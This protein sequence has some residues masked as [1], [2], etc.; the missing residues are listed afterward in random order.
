MT[1]F[2]ARYGFARDAVTLDNWRTRPFS[3]WSFQNVSEIVPSVLVAAGRGTEQP[4]EDNALFDQ[5][6]SVGERRVR[7][8]EFL[9]DS[10]T[11]IFT[12]MKKG[13]FVADYVATTCDFAGPHLL[14]SISKSLTA[15]LAGI[16]QDRGLL[17]PERPVTDF[18]PE[19]A[20]SAYGD[21]SLRH[22]LDMR[23]SVD[24]TEAYLD[25]ESA[26]ARYRRAMLWNPG[27]G[28]ETLRALIATLPKGDGP[29]GGPMR[30]LSP[31]SDLLG[32]VVE[33]I[34]GQRYGDMLREWLLEP[35]G[36]VGPCLVTNDR[37]GT[38]RAAGGVSLTARDLAR[39]GEMMRNGGMA[40]SRAVL[41]EAWVR[42]TTTAGDKDAWKAGDFAHLF[43]EG[44]YRNQWYQSG[45]QEGA[46]CAIGIHG[47]WL[48]VDPSA[49]VVIVR[50]A[51][52]NEPVDDALDH[53]C[54]DVFRQVA[55]LA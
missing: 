29:H 15:I 33:R 48:Y 26:F 18:V 32:I 44:S 41:S 7:L 27:D 8:S 31:N 13:A 10:W 23:A 35:V 52:Q 14:F 11:D 25:P 21:C 45:H 40:G 34:A 42:D 30:Y 2:E 47:Q 39:V 51:S 4:C 54:L 36:I 24:F 16:L 37:E 38:A 53:A 43:A 3:S 9:A 5:S 17:D 49:E 20:G 28:T 12:V 19:V 50:L 55:R 46:F 6:V 22:L 1:A